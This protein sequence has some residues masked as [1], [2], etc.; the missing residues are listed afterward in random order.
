MTRFRFLTFPLFPCFPCFLWLNFHSPE[1]GERIQVFDYKHEC[2][3]DTEPTPAWKH[4]I[5]S[6]KI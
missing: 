6:L 5:S 4:K 2:K 3:K 1:I